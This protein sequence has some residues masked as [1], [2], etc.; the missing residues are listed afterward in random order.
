MEEMIKEFMNS[1]VAD[2]KS[3][4][5]VEAYT[6]DL[7]AFADYMGKYIQKPVNTLKYSDLRRWVNSLEEGGLSVATRAKRIAS[8]RSFFKYLCKMDYIV[9]KNPTDGLDYPKIPKKQPKV[10]RSEDAKKIISVAKSNDSSHVTSF[11]DYAIIAM[12]LTTGIRREELSNVKLSDVDMENGAILIHGKGNKERC[13]YINDMLRP[14]LSEYLASHRKQFKTA[15]TSKYLFVSTRSEKITLAG[16]NLIVN[17][18]MEKAGI[19]EAGISAHILRKRF[20]TTVFENTGD[21]ATVSKLLGHSSP[22]VTMRYV[23]VGEDA[24]RQ[25][26]NAASF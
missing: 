25:A 13:V 24:M 19:K 23:S 7:I 18:S 9:G 1:L 10:I 17:G 11:R 26:T 15:D 12:F 3:K 4:R 5:T 21:I 16:I 14:I 20:A 6:L 8:V 22:T 2:G